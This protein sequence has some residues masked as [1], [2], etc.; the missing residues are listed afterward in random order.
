MSLN[1]LDTQPVQDA[2]N[3]VSIDPAGWFVSCSASFVSGCI[4]LTCVCRFLLKYVSRDTV[5]LLGSG[6][7]GVAEARTV[8]AQ[9]EDKSPLYGLIVFRRKRVLIKY[10][11]EG[12]SRLLQ[13]MSRLIIGSPHKTL[14]FFVLMIS[15]QLVPPCTSKTSCPNTRLMKRCWKSRPLMR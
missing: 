12:T 5:E 4:L 7:T 2:F 9:Y 10:I 8:V 14:C 1:G 3:S 11:P 15:A 13:G 6:N